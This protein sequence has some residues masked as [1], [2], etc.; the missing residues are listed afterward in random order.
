MRTFQYSERD[1]D[2]PLDNMTTYLY[3]ESLTVDA[4]FRPS[5]FCNTRGARTWYIGAI[6]P[7]RIRVRSSISGEV[8]LR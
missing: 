6:G 8:S 2:N 3:I 4:M 7:Q 1:I 5:D